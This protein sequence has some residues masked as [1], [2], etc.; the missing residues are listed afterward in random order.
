MSHSTV[1]MLPSKV[2]VTLRKADAVA[3]G[4]LEDPNHKPEPEVDLVP[5]DMDQPS[6]PDWDIDDDDI[7]DS[8][9]EWAYDT[10]KKE[11]EK[12]KE[13]ET[14]EEEDDMPELDG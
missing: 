12:K 13:G 2:E 10:G 1:S 14:K 4:K 9:E 5:S 3:W 11:E 7:S 6:H 8:D